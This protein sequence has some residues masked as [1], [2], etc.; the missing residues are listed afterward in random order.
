MN[1]RTDIQVDLDEVIVTDR[2]RLRYPVYSD[3]PHIWSACQTPGFND[4][5]PWGPPSS[6]A[7]I[8]EPF[9]SAQMRWVS[10]DEYS[11]AIELLATRDFVGWISIRRETDV[12]AWSIGFWIHPQQHGRGFATECARVI[13]EFGF[14]RL[15]ARQITA[16]H[17]AWNEASGRVLSRIGMRHVRSDPTGFT[18]NNRKVEALEYIIRRGEAITA[19]DDGRAR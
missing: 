11:F 7:E 10:G 4:G 1:R 6:L 16:V 13:L 14:S 12:G 17:A 2:C 5:L 15:N 19:D 9:R 3:I 8:N 18:Q